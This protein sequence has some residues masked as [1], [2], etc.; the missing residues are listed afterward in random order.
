MRMRPALARFITPWLVS[1]AEP[2]EAMG[3]CQQQRDLACSAIT[4][5][6]MPRMLV[7]ISFW[8]R[9]AGTPLQSSTPAENEASQRQAPRGSDDLRVTDLGDSEPITWHVRRRRQRPPARSP[10]ETISTPGAALRIASARPAQPRV[11]E[12]QQQHL[13]RCAPQRRF[14][15]WRGRGLEAVGALLPESLR[16]QARQRGPAGRSLR[17]RAGRSPPRPGG[18]H[19]SSTE[20]SVKYGPCHKEVGNG[21]R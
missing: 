19:V 1:S 11:P 8:S 2:V 20:Y 10:T 21:R 17:W 4:G 7:I 14:A 18:G 3:Q 15:H 6:S 9:T 12:L 5:E 13:A 16:V